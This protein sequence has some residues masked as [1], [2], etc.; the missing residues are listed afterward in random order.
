MSNQKKNKLA[1]I[2]IICTAIIG[3]IVSVVAFIWRIN[4]EIPTFL[5]IWI[6]FFYLHLLYYGLI[7]YKKPHGN[8][9]RYMMLILAIYVAASVI[10]QINVWGASWP[11]ILSSSFAA[12]AITY[13]AGRLNK[14]K[15]NIFVAV[16]ASLLLLVRCFWFLDQPD[17]SGADIALFVLDRCQPLFMWLTIV[18]IYFFRY[19]E[20]QEA[21]LEVDVGK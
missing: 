5:F 15:K 2:V 10:T 6:C 17:L 16:L 18:L 11:V 19:R 1:P 7:G 20:H 12:M 4:S 8:M 21:G 13:M 9:V 3:F 14:A